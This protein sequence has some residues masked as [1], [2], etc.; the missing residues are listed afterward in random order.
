MCAL[1]TQTPNTSYRRRA[2]LF[3]TSNARVTRA[4][5]GVPHPHGNT[6][7]ADGFKRGLIRSGTDYSVYEDF[8]MRGLD[9]AFYRHRSRYHTKYDTVSSLNGPNALWSMLEASIATANALTDEKAT[10]DNDDPV[11]YFDGK[12]KL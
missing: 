10:I 9:L 12:H 5:R 8:G 4:F 2:L 11:L 6:I 7:S 1:T 3:R